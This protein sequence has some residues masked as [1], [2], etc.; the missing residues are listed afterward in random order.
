MTYAH[1]FEAGG[2]WRQPLYPQNIS[3]NAYLSGGNVGFGTMYGVTQSPAS[4]SVQWGG[5]GGNTMMQMLGNTIGPIAS[6]LL[7]SS[8]PEFFTAPSHDPAMLGLH[9][10]NQLMLQ[11]IQQHAV[12]LDASMMRAQIAQAIAASQNRIGGPS[13]ADYATAESLATKASGIANHPMFQGILRMS[14]MDNVIDNI[15][16]ASGYQ[17]GESLFYGTRHLGLGSSQIGD[18]MTHIQNSM[19]NNGVYNAAFGH[20]LNRRE[21]ADVASSLYRHGVLR[22]DV[23]TEQGSASWARQMSGG[24]GLAANLRDIMGQDKSIPELFEMLNQMTGGGIE[25]MGTNDL[26]TMTDRIKAIAS[27]ANISLQVMQRLVSQGSQFATQLGMP[28]AAGAKI[29]VDSVARTHGITS[30]M[31]D[32]GQW[33]AETSNQISSSVQMLSFQGAMSA[34]GIHAAGILRLAKMTDN[35]VLNEIASSIRSGTISGDLK[36]VMGSTH[37]LAEALRSRGLNMSTTDIKSVLSDAMLNSEYSDEVADMVWESQGQE[38]KELFAGIASSMLGGD[39]STARAVADAAGAAGPGHQKILD[40][41]T[42]ALMDSGYSEEQARSHAL[43][44]HSRVNQDSY[45]K[46]IGGVLGFNR[47]WGDEAQACVVKQ[48]E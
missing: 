31:M 16:G 32:E 46:G 6:Q 12:G 1:Y 23:D 36:S 48:R 5:F 9:K 35:P 15:A 14:G 18:I 24:T 33:G 11:D 19:Y 22:P 8:F 7:G 40:A 45:F 29:A 34:E 37:S 47:R 26:R 43:G 44:I 17:M 25:Q 13:P 27:N 38:F 20:G 41:M 42:S 30:V 28:G 21:V 4:Q 10:A 3:Q 2:P 39:L